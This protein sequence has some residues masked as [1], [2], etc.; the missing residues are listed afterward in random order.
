MLHVLK[1][2]KYAD[3]AEAWFVNPITKKINLLMTV[4]VKSI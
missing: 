1:R 3:E 4:L 2:I